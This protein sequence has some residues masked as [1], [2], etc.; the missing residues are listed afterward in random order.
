MTPAGSSGSRQDCVRWRLPD[1]N[2]A[3][4]WLWMYLYLIV[5]KH[6]WLPVSV[7]AWYS[8][9]CVCNVYVHNYLTLCNLSVLMYKTVCGSLYLWH[10][11]GVLYW[12][13]CPRIIDSLLLWGSA[14]WHLWTSESHSQ[15]Y[16]WVHELILLGGQLCLP[17]FLSSPWRR[18]SWFLLL[19]RALCSS[20]AG[21]MN[22][23]LSTGASLWEATFLRCSSGA[24][25]ETTVFLNPNTQVWAFPLY[26]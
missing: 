16:L 18:W 17:R 19:V 23:L 15:Q 1:C 24:T 10:F 12:L 26:L 20:H 25:S 6:S 7:R 14:L 11:C 9:L 5:T 22:C 13:R 3:C 2:P 8:C 21:P 4:L